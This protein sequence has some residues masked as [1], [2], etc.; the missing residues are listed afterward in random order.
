MKWRQLKNYTDYKIDMKTLT[1]IVV[2]TM[3]SVSVNAQTWNEWFRQKKTQK[4]Y[5]VQQVVALKVYLEYLKAGYDIAQKGLNMV[6]DIKKGNFNDH[7]KYLGSLKLVN[8][9]VGANSKIAL[10][11]AYQEG[12]MNEFRLLNNECR[13][14]ENLRSEEI[15]Y[16][17]SVYSKLLTECENSIGALNT[18]ITTDASQMTDDERM[19]RIESIYL[20]MKDRYA[21]TKSFCNSTRMLVKQRAIEQN[22]VE[23]GRKLNLE[24]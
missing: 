6:G 9:T 5:L 3:F 21:F 11:A 17:G 1:M 19:G 20:E 14:N 12:I 2:A 7:S 8:P 24:L 18:I 15:S 16:I 13:N 23:A 4:Q 10:I 22:E